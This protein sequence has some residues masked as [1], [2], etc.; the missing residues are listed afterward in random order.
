MG[1]KLV[2]LTKHIYLY[3]SLAKWTVLAPVAGYNYDHYSNEIGI[4]KAN[5]APQIEAPKL[6]AIHAFACEDTWSIN[7]MHVDRDIYVYLYICTHVCVRVCICEST[8]TRPDETPSDQSCQCAGFTSELWM[9]II[10]VVVV[11]VAAVSW[12]SPGRSS[13]S[14][15]KLKTQN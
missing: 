6:I 5:Y 1:I 4:T 15:R 10:V 7:L 8:P 14:V 11:D 3:I 13:M 12:S 2:L 9:L